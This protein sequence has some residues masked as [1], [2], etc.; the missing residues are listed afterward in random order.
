MLQKDPN[1]SLQTVNFS[2]HLD[3]S[4]TFMSHGV[5]IS[6][7]QDLDTSVYVESFLN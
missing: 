5:C 7:P 2:Y 3:I 1:T 6:I 4:D